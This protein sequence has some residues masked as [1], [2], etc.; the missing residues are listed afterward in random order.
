MNDTT[1]TI[2]IVLGVALLVIVLLPLL[3]MGGMMGGMMRGQC[4]GNALWLTIGL[5]LLVLV[6]GGVFLIVRLRRQ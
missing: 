3:Y 6:A 1:R 2:L 5:G 4:C